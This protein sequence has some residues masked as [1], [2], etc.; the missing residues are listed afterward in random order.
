[1]VN[2]SEIRFLHAEGKYDEVLKK[3]LKV[4]MGGKEK[5]TI[6]DEVFINHCIAWHYF[7]KN[8]E[9]MKYYI[10]LNEKIFS[11]YDNRKNYKIEYAKHLWLYADIFNGELSKKEYVEIMLKSYV[12]YKEMGGNNYCENCSI[13]KV[14]MIKVNEDDI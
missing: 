2:K 10:N 4:K 6:S 9:L 12:L 1:M 3:L 14:A 13:L 7:K 8:D 11:I 5:D